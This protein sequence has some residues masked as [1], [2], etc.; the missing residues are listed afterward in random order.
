[1]CASAPRVL[2]H[3]AA[4]YAFCSASPIAYS[5][6]AWTVTVFQAS[7][8][9]RLDATSPSSA[10]A[11]TL[12]DTSITAASVNVSVY[13]GDGNFQFSITETAVWTSP[14]LDS[15]T[16]PEPFGPLLLRGA[17]AGGVQW[18]LLLSDTADASEH[19]AFNLSVSGGESPAV[20]V[21]VTVAGAQDEHVFGLGTQYSFYDLVDRAVAVWSS[22]QGVGRGL[23][24]I[25]AIVDAL[26]RGSGG[27]IN[28]TYTQFPALMSSTGR[29]LSLA[30]LEY[31]EWRFA[32]VGDGYAVR[33]LS[34]FVSG[35]VWALR[36][37]GLLDAAASFAHVTGSQPPLPAWVD[38]GAIVGLEGGTDAVLASLSRIYNVERDAAVAA[39]WIQDWT[40]GVNYTSGLPRYG[41]YWSWTGVN[42]STYPKWAES[43]LPALANHGSRVLVYANP[44]LVQ[45]GA[46][47]EDALSRGAL[48]QLAGGALFTTY[49]DHVLVDL[50][51]VSTAAWFASAL[52]TAFNSANATGGMIDFGEAFPVASADGLSKHGAFPAAW[53]SVAA[54]VSEGVGGGQGLFFM[55]SASAASPRHVPL[56]WLGDQLTSWD[57]FDGL[58]S[59]PRALL[60]AA[61][62]GMGVTHFDIGLYT[63]LAFGAVPV[64]ARSKELF[65]RSAEL[66]VF[67]W[68][69]RTH[70]GSDPSI[71]WQLTDDDD[72]ITRF[73][74]MQR[75]FTSL[76]PY[77]GEV[78]AELAAKGTPVYLPTAALYPAAPWGLDAQF[79]LGRKLLVAPVLKPRTSNVSVWLP[80]GVWRHALTNESF[81]G[82]DAVIV[83]QA[84][85]G[86]PAAFWAA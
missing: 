17:F 27:S 40:G 84:P 6:G 16:Q 69:F 42:S 18:S 20:A 29:G 80:R 83:V 45:S 10:L 52:V 30:N 54:T 21:S 24:P 48:V 59:I 9:W 39:V 19:L 62:C 77:R 61:L 7:N 3:T 58:A 71:N 8:S 82:S 33:C 50:T 43:L 60:S 53:A 70:P 1:M 34:S 64:V 79:F 72:T 74:V 38:D 81:V 78:A 26:D 22:E 47:Y 51:N 76:A 35:R 46:L 37:G 12:Y 68:A 65:L 4:L 86:V 14:S 66:A 73:F 56:F 57:E 63:S 32:G 75:V 15:Q 67:T 2:L 41:V 49:G 11:L 85:I 5:V 23:Q 44:H 28:T 13:E 25:T 36:G 31:S 55:R